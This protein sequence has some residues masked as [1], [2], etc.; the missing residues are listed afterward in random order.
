MEHVN[1][2]GL[3]YGTCKSMWPLLSLL[4]WQFRRCQ[5]VIIALLIVVCVTVVQI[6]LTIYNISDTPR[7]IY[8]KF[9]RYVNY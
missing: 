8:F 3:Y 4:A 5:A 7:D 9:G 6:L 2:C 1:L